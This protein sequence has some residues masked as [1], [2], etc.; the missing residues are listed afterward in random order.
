MFSSFGY[1]EKDPLK[2]FTMNIVFIHLNTK[3]PKFLEYNLRRTASIS[4]NSKV[5]LLH[6]LEDEVRISGIESRRMFLSKEDLEVESNYGF[7]RDFRSNFWFTSVI[8]FSFLSRFMSSTKG[9]VLHIE[10][11]VLISSDFPFQK[12]S[13]IGSSLAYPIVSKTRGI[14]STLYIRDKGNAFDLWTFA[15]DSIVS[16]PLVSDMEILYEFYVKRP[17]LVTALPI[18]PLALYKTNKSS[19]NADFIVNQSQKAELLGG[20]F[21]GHDFG[22]Y[23]FGSNPWN[24]RYGRSYLHR[25]IEHSFLELNTRSFVFDKRREFLNIVTS[26]NGEDSVTKL[27]SLHITNKNLIFFHARFTALSLLIWQ[28]TL[29]MRVSMTWH[30]FVFLRKVISKLI[31]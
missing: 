27:F 5:Y 16:N 6:N 31:K 28:T 14:A 26:V 9:E 3:L 13:H 23:A 1:L 12:I 7:P 21:D 29:L 15:R 25:R 8:R 4:P 20:V 11:D 24:D 22:V 10:S 2:D 30:P 17:E 19:E 18:A